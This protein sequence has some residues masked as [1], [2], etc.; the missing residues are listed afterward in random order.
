MR[1]IADEK[2]QTQTLNAWFWL[3]KT[4]FE[5]DFS[6]LRSNTNCMQQGPRAIDFGQF[7][8]YINSMPRACSCTDE[9]NKKAIK[10]YTIAKF[11]GFRR[12]SE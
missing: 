12:N 1:L 9:K 5:F 11:D 6:D 8:V 10:I 3:I 4:Q 7:G 2:N